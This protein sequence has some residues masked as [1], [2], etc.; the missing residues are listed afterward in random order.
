MVLMQPCSAPDYRIQL[1]PSAKFLPSTGEAVVS[2]APAMVRICVGAQRFKH[3]WRGSRWDKLS[4]GMPFR[5]NADSHAR[6]QPPDAFEALV[7]ECPT[8][9]QRG[10]IA[11]RGHAA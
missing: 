8:G 9:C 1:L 3:R 6:D 2:V 5:P 4:H 7:S 11:G 10:E